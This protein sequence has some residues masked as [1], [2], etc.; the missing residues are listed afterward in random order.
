M[1]HPQ[2]KSPKGQVY[3]CVAWAIDFGRTNWE[4][5]GFEKE[6]GNIYFGFVHGFEDEFG[7]F[8][9]DELRENGIKLIT[10]PRELNQIA[11]PIG[12]DFA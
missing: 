2:Y 5:Y 3:T 4:W 9:A 10:D 12:W 11:P 6:D 7:Y 1:K 8:S